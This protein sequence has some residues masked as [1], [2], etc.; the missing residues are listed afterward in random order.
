MK[1]KPRNRAYRRAYLRDKEGRLMWKGPV[2]TAW[3]RAR[4]D[5]VDAPK[6]AGTTGVYTIL[7][8]PEQFEDSYFERHWF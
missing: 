6:I 3:T 5:L 7:D 1:P 8:N 4:V 2:R